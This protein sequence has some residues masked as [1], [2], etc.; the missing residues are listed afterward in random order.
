MDL[1]TLSETPPWEWPDN[2]DQKL[3]G[4]LRDSR[5]RDS[6]RFV[7]AELAGDFTVI[8][9]ELA[10]ALLSILRDGDESEKMRSRAALSLGPA[11]EE[12]YIEEFEDPEAV[13]ITEPMFNKVQ[14]TLRKVYM[15]PD[16]PKEVRRRVLE[17]SVHAPED[18]HREAVRAAYFTD[19]EDWKLT[20]VFCM[21]FLRGFDEQILESLQSENPDIHYEAVCAAGNWEVDAAWPHV[22]N[23]ALSEGTD[24]LL[25]MAAIEAVGSIRPVEASEILLRLIRHEDEEIADAA[26][27]AM[28]MAQMVSEMEEEEEDKL[29]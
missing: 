8:S 22:S 19:D 12:A 24:K 3:L 26:E 6:D 17:A 18:W 21:R 2:T 15:D 13:P 1:K 11:L 14:K 5:V 27:E 29:E 23:L 20:S 7:A 28:G 9:D 16:V 25:R 4:I 10:G